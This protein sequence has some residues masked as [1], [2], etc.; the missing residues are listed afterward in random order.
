MATY[1]ARFSKGMCKRNGWCHVSSR[2]D[3]TYKPSSWICDVR[4]FI[5][6]LNLTLSGS[7]ISEPIYTWRGRSLTF[8]DITFIITVLLCVAV[9][10]VHVIVSCLLDDY[11]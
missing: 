7:A 8:D 10:D 5:P 9:V 2:K 3:G 11:V 1:N 6:L 4:F